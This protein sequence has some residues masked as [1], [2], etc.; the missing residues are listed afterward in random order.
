MADEPNANRWLILIAYLMGLSTGVHLLNLL[1]VPAIGMVYY[2]K[3]YTFSWKGVT[4]A[5]AVS[6]GILAAI[7]YVIIP[8]VP[9]IYFRF[10]V[11]Q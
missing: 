9:G 7:Q 11:C 10:I 3:K 8:G 2:F 1:A 5:L 4:V 6:I